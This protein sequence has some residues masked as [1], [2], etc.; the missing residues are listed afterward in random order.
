[1]DPEK[2]FSFYPSREEVDAWAERLAVKGRSRRLS[3]E[4]LDLSP[5]RKEFGNSPE[6]LSNRYV[7]F[8]SEDHAFY[9]YWQPSPVQ[10]AP[11]LVH[12]P[13]Y[14]GYITMHPSI[15]SD[16]F[17]I[18]HVSPLGYV[19]PSGPAK[20]VLAEDGKLP[21]LHNTAEGKRGGYE[22]WLLDCVSAASWAIERPEVLPGRLSF[23]GTS[24]GGGAA[25]LLASIMKGQVRS[26]AADLP[27]L[28]AFPLTDLEGEAYSMLK[29]SY[30]KV[31][32][33][34]FWNRLGYVD[35]LSHAHRISI[36]VMLTA[37]GRDDV[38]FPRTVE[39]LFS[40]LPGTKQYT[41]LKDN[42]HDHSREGNALFR[43]W[44]SLYA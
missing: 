28:T 7:R 21:V 31:R 15:S 42:G 16:G 25:L 17:N 1:M 37:G 44:F 20:G 34:V 5:I 23:F 38:C 32:E 10:P 6:A 14:G 39:R 33:D 2:A 30:G 12:L 35:T 4:L 13:G 9:G 24:Q 11:L 40:I 43:S 8:E 18:L 3:A 19:T 41:Y 29:P 26:V 22:D 27:F 36:P